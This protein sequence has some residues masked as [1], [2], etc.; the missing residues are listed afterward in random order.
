MKLTFE[1]IK[2]ITVGAAKIIEK[3][4]GIHFLKCTEKQ[5]E[6]WMNRNPV[7]GK[8]S[9]ISTGVRLDF[10]TDSKKL[11]FGVAS[12]VKYEVYVNGLMRAQ[13]D[14]SENREVTLEL[15]DPLGQSF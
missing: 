2:G 12:G 15:G 8:H 11:S 9:S 13:Y 14:M 7:L 3:Q 5:T 10:H 4:D 6:V 1:Q